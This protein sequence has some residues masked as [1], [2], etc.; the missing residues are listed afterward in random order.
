MVDPNV[1]RAQQVRSSLAHLPLTLSVSALNSALLGT[2][3]FEL[4]Q[5]DNILVWV[6]IQLSLSSLRLIL[7][8][9]HYQFAAKL[10]HYMWE[11]LA[12][13]GGF[14]SGIAWGYAP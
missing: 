4:P 6:A 11:G 2:A 3:F 8:Y 7:W 1:L 14:L 12:I 9:V 10:R 5:R 13:C